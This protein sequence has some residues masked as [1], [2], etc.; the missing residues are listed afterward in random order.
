MR[1]WRAVSLLAV[2]AV[3]ALNVI[4]VVRKVSPPPTA[5]APDWMVDYVTRCER[6]FAKFREH[7][8]A[9]G[10][11]GAIGYVESLRGSDA[12]LREVE[13]DYFVAQFV[14]LPLL[15]EPQN[16]ARHRWALGNFLTPPPHALPAGWR[17][18]E[19][20]GDGVLLLGTTAP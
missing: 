18:V 12:A 1:L 7:A 13:P 2:V 20:F 14:V 3:A 15:L 8:R 19:D 9:R 10:V 4:H 17:V 6:R 5:D 16:T 11:T